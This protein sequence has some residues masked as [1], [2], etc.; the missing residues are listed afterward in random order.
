M[1]MSRI[2]ILLFTDTQ[3]YF[4]KTVFVLYSVFYITHNT[5]QFKGRKNE[6]AKY[7][8]E[9]V[10]KETSLSYKTVFYIT[11]CQLL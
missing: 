11:N 5:I 1:L 2:D 4:L 6:T 9:K 10:G 3:I 8:F 7:N